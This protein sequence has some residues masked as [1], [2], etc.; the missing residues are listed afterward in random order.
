MEAIVNELSTLSPLG[1]TQA[2]GRSNLN[3]IFELLS[4]L[5][6]VPYSIT[7][8]RVNPYPLLNLCEGFSIEDWYKHPET[9]HTEK[10]FYVS[11]FH[12]QFQN[13][14]S[15]KLSGL[16]ELEH[17]DFAGK[18]ALGFG[19][20]SENDLPCI[21]LTRHECW[22]GT[23]VTLKFTDEDEQIRARE[24]IHIADESHLYEL[25]TWFDERTSIDLVVSQW[26][27]EEK[28][29]PFENQNHHETHK[30]VA[31][32]QKIRKSP[33]VNRIICSKPNES[34]TEKF[35]FSLTS[36]NRIHLVLVNTDRGLGLEIETTAK[37]ERENKRIAEILD[38]QYN[39]KK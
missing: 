38:R 8:L 18:E 3:R 27:P 14:V 31:F 30:L 37:N 9:K 21:S 4:K 34:Y 19:F 39:P 10:N 25:S 2:E 28:I 17:V 15:I 16:Y 23:R 6:D 32:A 33:Y 29:I 22:S 5:A 1:K 7:T 20:A 35:V 26:E 12:K 24:A 36:P 13:D 11:R